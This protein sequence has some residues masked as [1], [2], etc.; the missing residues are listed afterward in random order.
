[1][2]KKERLWAVYKGEEPDRIPVKLWG[3]D[4]NQGMMHPAYQKVYDLAIEKT[5]L[6]G[7]AGSPMDIYCGMNGGDVYTWHTEPYNED[8]T[9]HITMIKTASGDL[10]NIFLS[11]NKG[12]PGLNKEYYIKTP[13]DIKKILSLK[14]D[15]FPINLTDYEQAIERM[16]DDGIVMFGLHHPAYMF[17]NLTGSETLGYLLYDA[18]DLVEEAI[19]TFSKRIN[20]FLRGIV[21]AGISK[22]GP[23]TVAY[24]GPE[25]LIPPLVSF[26]MFDKLVFDMD[27]PNLDIV[28]NAGGYVWVHC[29]GKTGK[30]ISRFAE[31]GVDILNPIEPP[32]MGDCDIDAAIKAAGGRIT[33]EGNIEIN[34]IINQD[35]EYIISFLENTVKKGSAYKRF[36]LCPSAGYMEYIQ[37]S[38]KYINNLITYINYG[39]EFSKK[40]AGL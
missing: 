36:I 35:E 27:K 3:L 33:L 39:V 8:W 19:Y 17:Y 30:L 25:L 26:E 40:Y 34:D 29:H 9:S 21:D 24:V 22:Y 37:P 12:H 1:M 6:I 18:P 14:Y 20:G 2:T 23:F 16:G 10:K 31:M 15:P 7:G 11:N 38:E 13:E 32:P 4:K 28:K 5:D